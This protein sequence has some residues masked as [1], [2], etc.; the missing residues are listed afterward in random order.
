M[1]LGQKA[2]ITGGSK[3]LGLAIATKLADLGCSITLVARNESLLKQ[4]VALLSSEGHHDYSV[5]DLE[6]PD[7]RQLSFLLQNKSILV[8]CA[9]ITNHSLLARLSDEEIFSTIQVNLTMPIVLAKLSYKNMLKMNS[10]MKP[11]ILNIASVLSYTG[12]TMPGTLVYAALKA[13]LLGFTQSL[14]AEAKGKIRVNSLLPGLIAETD[15]G[16][17]VGKGIKSIALDD[18]A[19]QAVDMITDQ[20]LNGSNI[21][22]DAKGK[23]SA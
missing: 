21:I 22:Y 10:D 12:I 14:A 16:K 8:N 3:G 15:M 13:G 5:I 6:Q 7:Y 4:N 19:Q 17:S 1:L 18:C 2:L 20:K 11:T 9:G 23:R